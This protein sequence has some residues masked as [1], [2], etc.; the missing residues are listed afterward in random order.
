MTND[1]NL[2]NH[3]S[4]AIPANLSQSDL[5]KTLLER[6][7]HL[8]SN[9]K[10]ALLLIVVAV[11]VIVVHQVFAMIS[12][13]ITVGHSLTHIMLLTIA[14]VLIYGAWVIWSCYLKLHHD[15]KA[16]L[17][18][19]ANTEELSEKTGESLRKSESL[20]ESVFGAITDRRILIVDQDNRIVKANRIAANWAGRDPT[21]HEFTEIYPTC[22]NQGERLNELGLIKH[23]R[24]TQKIC[25]GHLLRGGAD[26][27]MLLSIDTYPVNHQDNNSNLVIAIAR[28]VTE[29]TGRKLASRHQEKMAS[30]GLLVAGFAHDLGNPLASLSSE[31]ELL[32]E[33]DPGKIR[34]SLDIVNEHVKRIKRKLHDIVKFAHRPDENKQD[35]D[36]REAIDH[37]LKLTRYDYRA[38]RIQF[39]IDTDD[40]PPVQIKNDDLVLILV[41]VII[42]AFDAMPQGGELSINASMTPTG[43]VLLTVADTGVGM[44]AATLQQATQ[45]LF[46][47]KNINNGTGLGLTM[48]DQLIGSAGGELT[49]ASEPGCGSRIMLR[50]PVVTSDHPGTNRKP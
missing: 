29:Q 37:A 35:V 13:P 48:V 25:R 42:N 44:D 6:D 31:L 19:Y 38:R 34:E 45:P 16:V 47:T 17:D 49:L 41:N 36:I 14:V 8:C 20:L 33:E 46:T 28:D 1:S 2:N 7:I 26:C 15:Q 23:T 50:L 9:L 12:Y 40:V 30:L 39:N 24:E 3:L 10:R 22:D 18:A 27:S 11:I 32:R 4:S 21:L 43:D 5:R